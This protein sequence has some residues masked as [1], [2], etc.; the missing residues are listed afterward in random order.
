MQ[1]LDVPVVNPAI[2]ERLN[3]GQRDD[4]GWQLV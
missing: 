4:R 2:E 1:L 3:E